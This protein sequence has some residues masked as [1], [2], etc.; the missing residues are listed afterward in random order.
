M[1]YQ[2]RCYNDNVFVGYMTHENRMAWSKNVA[3]KHALEYVALHG[4]YAELEE[5]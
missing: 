5:V 3:L 4:G 1:K 2:I